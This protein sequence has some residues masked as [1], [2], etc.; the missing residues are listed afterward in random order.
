MFGA[1]LRWKRF[2]EA[3]SLRED[4]TAWATKR[5]TVSEVKNHLTPVGNGKGTVVLG[6][7]M[8]PSGRAHTNT[9]KDTEP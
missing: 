3:E 6:N 5:R 4:E 2:N 8:N 7:P 1:E 9:P